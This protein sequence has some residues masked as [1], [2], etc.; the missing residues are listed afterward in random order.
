MPSSSKAT[1]AEALARQLRL[2]LIAKDEVKEPL[3]ESLGADDLASSGRLGA[4]AYVLIFALPRT[5]L[6]AGVFIIVEA[7]FLRDTG[8]RGASGAPVDATPV[9]GSLSDPA[10]AVREPLGAMPGT[11]TPRR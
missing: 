1:V 5:M 2:P 7:N 11:T 6:A 4:A 3:Y 8:L 9:R 10:R